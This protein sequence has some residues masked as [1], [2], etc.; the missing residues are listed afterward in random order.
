MDDPVF[1]Q[2]LA[3]IKDLSKA[4]TDIKEILDDLRPADIDLSEWG[5]ERGSNKG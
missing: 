3:L 2:L 5:L 4:M 1:E